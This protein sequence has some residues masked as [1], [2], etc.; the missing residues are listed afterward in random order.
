LQKSR[1]KFL[2]KQRGEKVKEGVFH[3][4][5]YLGSDCTANWERGGQLEGWTPETSLAVP[6]LR[7]TECVF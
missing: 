1:R 6:E 2:R 3:H 4:Q 5:Y 7:S